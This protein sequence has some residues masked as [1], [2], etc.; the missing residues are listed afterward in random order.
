MVERA[1]AFFGDQWEALA[2]SRRPGSGRSRVHVLFVCPSTRDTLTGHVDDSGLEDVT[3]ETLCLAL[4]A[5]LE[6]RAAAKKPTKSEMAP[7]C[8]DA[9]TRADRLADLLEEFRIRDDNERPRFADL[10][11]RARIARDRAAAIRA[12]RWDTQRVFKRARSK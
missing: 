7:M 4:S 12:R 6:R 10:S 9:I 1:F 2:T 3:D 5:A 11:A 8:N